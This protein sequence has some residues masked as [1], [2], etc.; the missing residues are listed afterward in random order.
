[1]IMDTNE[2]KTV[3]FSNV[4]TYIFENQKYPITQPGGKLCFIK[5]GD[6]EST[7]FFDKVDELLNFRIHNKKIRNIITEIEPY[8]RCF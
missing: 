6:E 2:R 7:Q 1:M 5:I 3:Y 4:L 8:F